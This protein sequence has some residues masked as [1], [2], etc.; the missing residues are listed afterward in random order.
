MAF[1][2]DGTL[3]CAIYGQ[4]DVCLIGQ[5]GA[6]SGHIPTN[7]LLPGNIAFT[8]DGK[9]A[10]ITEQARGVVE[11]I[12]APRPGMPLHMPSI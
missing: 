4:G 12:P 5:T 3:Y 9:Y 7:G 10:L 6:I 11:R 8:P 1:D 2:R